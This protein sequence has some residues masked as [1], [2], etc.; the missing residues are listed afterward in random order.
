M[1]TDV[2]K[3]DERFAAMAQEYA[4]VERVSGN[5]ISTKGGVLTYE[6]EPL[7]GNQM[8]VIILDVVH[9]RTFYAEKYDSSR[10]HATPPVCYAFGRTEEDVAEMAP[11]PTMQVDLSYFQPQSDLCSTCPNNEWGSSDTGR[12][13]ACAERRRMALL[14]AGYF[15]PKRGSRDF[16]LNLFDDPKHFKSADIAYLKLPVMSVKDWARYVT[17][18]AA[19]LRRPPLAVISR[20]YLEPDPKSQFRVKFEMIEELP[21]DLYEIV[22]ERHR[23]AKTQIIQGYNPPSGDSGEDDAPK[24]RQSAR[25]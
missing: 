15:T 14:P 20:V 6:N 9:E 24:R 12:G 22:M 18:I 3:Y 1:A 16:D 13:K 7:P 25:R 11:H 17:D 4:Q 2:T 21:S 5:F 8:A 10:E 19:S 23:E